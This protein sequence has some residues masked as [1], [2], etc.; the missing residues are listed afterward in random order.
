MRQPFIVNGV[1]KRYDVIYDQERPLCFDYDMLVENRDIDLHRT[2]E[3]VYADNPTFD[4]EVN[5]ADAVERQKLKEEE[6]LP[7]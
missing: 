7:F 3:E 1:I 4:V 6:I 5:D 2:T